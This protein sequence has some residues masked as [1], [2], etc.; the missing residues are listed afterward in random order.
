[1]TALPATTQPAA[2]ASIAPQ[3]AQRDPAATLAWAQAL[4]TPAA[5]EAAT[6]AAYARW[7]D[8]A[9]AAARAWLAAANL[10]AGLKSK[11]ATPVR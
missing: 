9:P 2:A 11:L 1:V 3:L 7:L 5:R 10:D 6:T 4:P 8:N